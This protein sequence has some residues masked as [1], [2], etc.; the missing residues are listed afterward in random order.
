[1][2]QFVEECLKPI[3]QFQWLK[4]IPID[5][6]LQQNIVFMVAYFDKRLF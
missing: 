5:F 3:H 6:E 2:Q 4:T 1:M